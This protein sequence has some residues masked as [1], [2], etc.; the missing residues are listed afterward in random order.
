MPVKQKAQGTAEALALKEKQ[1]YVKGYLQVVGNLYR[2]Q[3]FTQEQA[4]LAELAYKRRLPPSGF[5]ALVRAHDPA[6][7]QTQDFKRRATEAAN[8]WKQFR[9]GRPVP[10][11]YSARYVRSNLN[12][13]QLIEKSQRATAARSSAASFSPTAANPAAY[14]QMREML[15]ASFRLSPGPEQVA[16]PSLHRMIFS[17]NMR[18]QEINDQISELF[19]GKNVFEWM[20]GVAPQNEQAVRDSLFKVIPQKK[21]STAPPVFLNQDQNQFGIGV[22][23]LSASLISSEL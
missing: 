14:R 2:R 8:V 13:Q 10:Q 19:G 5:V 20:K 3:N 1:R 21:L 23:D 7:P 17:A 6:Y 15:N 16:H 18:E 9:P 11:E 4:R 12:Q 22:D